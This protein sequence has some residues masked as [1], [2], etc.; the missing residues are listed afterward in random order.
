[1]LGTAHA[2]YLMH[3][4][5]KH[6]TVSDPEIERIREIEARIRQEVLEGMRP[7]SKLYQPGDLTEVIRGVLS[8]ALA[9]V[10]SVHNR[11]IE[12][13]AKGR[14]W[15][16]DVTMLKEKDRAGQKGKVVA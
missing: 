10:V 9:R 16:V 14:N 6:L 1:M 3:W 2:G 8:G 5:N 4:D 11:R 7:K 12:I 15:I 13:E